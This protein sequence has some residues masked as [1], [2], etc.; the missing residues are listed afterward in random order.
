MADCASA[1]P[2]RTSRAALQTSSAANGNQRFDRCRRAWLCPQPSR[3]RAKV[4]SVG[5]TKSRSVGDTREVRRASQRAR[6]QD[7]RVAAL[8]RRVSLSRVSAELGATRTIAHDVNVRPERLEAASSGR[9]QCSKS[10]RFVRSFPRVRFE[11]KPACAIERLPR[12]P[13]VA[14]AAPESETRRGPV[15]ELTVP[16][17]CR[18]LP[19]GVNSMVLDM[20]PPARGRL[21][22]GSESS[23][24]RLCRT[25][26]PLLPAEVVECSAIV[27]IHS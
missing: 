1:V 19:G 15:K 20:L 8:L 24:S 3:S 26:H 18:H 9:E 10:A 25:A 13:A 2:H 6:E 7:H 21:T 16:E 12:E 22:A 17:D 11:L 4:L 14:N 5:T 27:S 23:R